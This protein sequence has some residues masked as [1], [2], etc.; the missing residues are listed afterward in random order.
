[1]KMHQFGTPTGRFYRDLFDG[2][3]QELSDN[4]NFKMIDLREISGKGRTVIHA[5]AGRIRSLDFDPDLDMHIGPDALGNQVWWASDDATDFHVNISRWVQTNRITGQDGEELDTPRA[6]TTDLTKEQFAAVM[7]S[8][9][10]GRRTER[11]WR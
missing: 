11:P 2:Y 7:A 6:T 9:N 8:V 3:S 10:E 1:M 5:A 4:P